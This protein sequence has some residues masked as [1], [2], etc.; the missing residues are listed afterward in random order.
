MPRRAGGCCHR[1]RPALP[2]QAEA[3]RVGPPVEGALV[4]EVLV[5]R[6]GKRREVPRKG[7]GEVPAVRREH[8]WGRERV[9]ER[10]PR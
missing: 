5:K 6:K 1:S 8:Q 4:K 2:L 9:P 3:G 7:P 10:E